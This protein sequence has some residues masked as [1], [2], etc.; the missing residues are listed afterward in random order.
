MTTKEKIKILI[1]ANYGKVDSDE[2]L[3]LLIS[4]NYGKGN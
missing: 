4:T 3:K 1:S 2:M